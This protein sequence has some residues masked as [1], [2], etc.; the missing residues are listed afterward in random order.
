MVRQG[1]AARQFDVLLPT[2][3][4]ENLTDLQPQASIELS[5]P[6][7]WY[8]HNMIFTVPLHMGLATSVFHLRSSRASRGLPREDPFYTPG[9]AEPSKY[10]P[11]ELVV[12]EHELA[13]VGTSVILGQFKEDSTHQYN[14]IS[15]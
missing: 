5:P 8:N 7:F 9:T 6:V 11:A 13:I 10:T 2:Q 3:L 15:K 4:A 14:W 12:Y 1:I